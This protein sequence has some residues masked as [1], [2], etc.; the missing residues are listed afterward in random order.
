M[1]AVVAA[2][3][4]MPAVIAAH[5]SYL[6]PAWWLALVAMQPPQLWSVGVGIVIAF[7]VYSCGA[8]IG[9]AE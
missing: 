8:L 5:G 1:R 6:V 9:N 3:C 4:F 2:V 7:A